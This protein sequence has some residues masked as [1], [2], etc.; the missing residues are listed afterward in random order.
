M[1][2]ISVNMMAEVLL[3]VVSVFPDMLECVYFTEI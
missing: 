2:N 1:Y 3:S